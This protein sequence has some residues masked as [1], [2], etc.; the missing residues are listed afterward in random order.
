[1]GDDGEDGMLRHICHALGATEDDE[2]RALLLSTI[3][4]LTAGTEQP[5]L[6]SCAEHLLAAAVPSIIR[7]L[8]Q[9]TDVHCLHLHLQC[10]HA[11][12]TISQVATTSR[13]I[14]RGAN[15]SALLERKVGQCREIAFA[16]RCASSFTEMA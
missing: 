5:A 6:S 15:C 1:M 9:D 2:C 16:E 13:A 8:L 3:A 14:L 10:A 11:L 4:S 12:A 7:I